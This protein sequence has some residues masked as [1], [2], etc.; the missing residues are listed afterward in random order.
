MSTQLTKTE[1]NICA[2][3]GPRLCR[4]GLCCLADFIGERLTEINVTSPT[5]IREVQAL[6]G[7]DLGM[8]YVQWLESKLDS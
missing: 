2:A 4:D 1:A 6:T 8:A 3:V 7:D 5:G